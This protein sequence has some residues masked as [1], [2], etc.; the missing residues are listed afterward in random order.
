MDVFN[1]E[2]E[3][4]EWRKERRKNSLWKEMAYAWETTQTASTVFG[5]RFFYFFFSSYT[6]KVFW[7]I[8]IGT[9]TFIRT[10]DH[11]QR[12]SRYTVPRSNNEKKKHKPMQVARSYFRKILTDSAFPFRCLMCTTRSPTNRIRTVKHSILFGTMK[13]KPLI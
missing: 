8:Y 6:I 12:K 10:M 4:V 1:A 5:Q 2:I 11:C 13:V 7:L 9:Y 3:F